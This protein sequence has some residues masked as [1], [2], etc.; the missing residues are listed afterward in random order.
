M[1]CECFVMSGAGNLFSVLDNRTNILSLADEPRWARAFCVHDRTDGLLVLANAVHRE[2]NFSMRYYNN[3]G[4]TGAM[5][6]NGGRCIVEFA[7]ECGVI[8]QE[9]REVQF[10]CVGTV[11]RAERLGK[12]H[13]RLLFAPPRE[14]TYPLHVSFQSA[15]HH[16]PIAL[17]VA[18]TDVAVDHCVVYYPELGNQIRRP[19]DVFD[20]D[21]YGSALRHHSAFARGA[22]VNFYTIVGENTI[23]LRTYERG[24]ERETGACGSGALAVALTATLRHAMTLPIRIIPTSGEILTI[25]AYPD[26]NM[27]ESLILEGPARI[28]SQRVIDFNEFDTNEFFD[29]TSFHG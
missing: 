7:A 28:L 11:F 3:D 9:Q 20:I 17:T 18:Y 2:S 8:R 24:V 27:I 4:S 6:G 25:D 1:Q 14:F 29:N 21:H 19:F 26:D 16:E 10:D 5:C 23:K 12:E 22:N 15:C 13:I